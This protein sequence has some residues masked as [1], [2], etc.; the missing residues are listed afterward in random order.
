MSACVLDVNRRARAVA[1]LQW[2]N[3]V[4]LASLQPW[5]V[6]GSNAG[7][8]RRAALNPYPILHRRQQRV[9][10]DTDEV[11]FVGGAPLRDDE[12]GA[13]GRETVVEKPEEDS[14][15]GKPISP[16]SFAPA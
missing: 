3:A 14:I 1:A 15:V 4:R 2:W 13:K 9:V 12:G 6:R 7:F 8:A 11:T 16:S 10:M 5:L